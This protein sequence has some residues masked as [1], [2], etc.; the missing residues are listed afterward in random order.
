M[1]KILIPLLAIFVCSFAQAQNCPGINVIPY[2][3]EI[4][5]GD[6]LIFTATT[7]NLKVNVTYNWSVSAGK[8]VSGQ[9]MARIYVDTKDA[10]GSFITA[11]V[12]L[13]GL[14][15]K[16]STTASASSNVIPGAQ[17]VVS[18]TFTNGQELKNAVQKF[19][20]ASS[21]KDPANTATCFIYLYHAPNTSA[22]AMED[23]KQA[24]TGAFNFNKV[25]PDQYKIVD[26]GKKNLNNYEFYYLVAGGKEPRPSN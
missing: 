17:L 13:R 22:G 15:E 23:F 8:I 20:A 1:K 14:P 5:A 9:G 25:T 10:S 18:G 21:F 11:T 3:D 7:T 6:T 26:G 4:T 16:C 12:Q 2:T 19:I 24:I